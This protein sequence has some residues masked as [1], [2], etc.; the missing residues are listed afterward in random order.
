MYPQGDSR[1]ETN[2]RLQDGNRCFP[3]NSDGSRYQYGC[4]A[5]GLPLPA[6]AVTGS[7]SGSRAHLRPDAADCANPCRSRTR[8]GSGAK[9]RAT[10]GRYS[11]AAI[12]A[13]AA[14]CGRTKIC[15][16]AAGCCSLGTDSNPPASAGNA[17]TSAT[18]AGGYAAA[19]GLSRCS[20]APRLPRRSATSGLPRR[21]AAPGLP[22]RSTTTWLLCA[23]LW[24]QGLA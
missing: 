23:I 2:I 24:Q 11:C 8:A 3:G 13:S 6:A 4:C 15:S 5:T 9:I 22:R 1:Y 7:W 21:S 19:P 10:S 16:P 20:A 12:R 18:A 17:A 14:R